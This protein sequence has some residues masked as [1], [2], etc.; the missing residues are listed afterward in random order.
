MKI[1]A[2]APLAW[3]SVLGACGGNDSPNTSTG[4][5]AAPHP[6]MPQVVSLGGPVLAAPKLVEITFQGDPLQS[7]IDTFMQQLAGATAYWAGATAEYGVG[8]LTDITGVTLAETPAATATDADVQ[9]WLKGKITAHEVPQ[10]DKNTVYVIYYP[11]GASVTMGGGTL[12]GMGSS[13]FEG[14]HD[15]FAISPGSFV[16][17]AIAGRCPSAVASLPEI[18]EVSAE[19]SHEIIEA[20]TDPLPTDKPAFIAIDPDHLAWELIAGPEVADMCAGNPDAFFT[21]PGI[22]TVVQ[23][24]W[25]N[26][27]A[28][29]SH[30]P[31]QPYGTSP[32]F[33]SAPVLDDTV[34]IPN[35]VFGPLE[36]K[37]VQIPLGTSKT[38]ELDLYSD[39]P[40]SGPWEV[41]AIDLSSTFFGSATPALSFSFDKTSGQNGD[42]LHM[43]IQSLAAGPLG[44]APFW[45][46]SDLKTGAGVESKFWVGVVGN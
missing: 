9:L 25:S 24:V 42:K 4:A 2:L 26:V 6:P 18:D 41:S 43:T 5:F 22:T 17:Y 23:H 36:T 38:I 31:C 32:Y 27:S 1:R 40:T 39:A 11:Q 12:C 7:E 35:T 34:Q 29:G 46:E 45:I 44:A 33:N 30:D 14:Y 37:G 21:P 16:S 28:A 8:P 10:P 13:D 19:A 3:A 15:D 20:A